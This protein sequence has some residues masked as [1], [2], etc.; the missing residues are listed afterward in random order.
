MAEKLRYQ[1]GRSFA[2]PK[3]RFGGAFVKEAEAK[4]AMIREWL[5]APPERRATKEQAAAFA[6]GAVGRYSF[7]PSGDPYQEVNGWP[8]AYVG[9][10]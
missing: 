6:M 5:Q 3:G 9:L 8:Q 4:E 2:S 1:G 7:K 10:P